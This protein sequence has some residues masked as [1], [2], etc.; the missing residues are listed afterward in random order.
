MSEIGSDL[1]AAAGVTFPKFARETQA[2]LARVLSDLGQMHNP[3]DLTGAAVRDESVW[4]SVPAIVSRD[5][6]VGLTLVNW[7]VPAVAEPTM[8]NTLELVGQTHKGVAT[9]TLMIT[10][11]ERPV[12]EHGLAYLRRHGL[13]FAAPGFGHGIAAVGK[14]AW[15]SERLKRPS[16][17]SA[18]NATG[19][20]VQRPRDERETLAHLA[21]HGVPR[22]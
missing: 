6:A 7:D 4:T 16:P 5:P 18:P 10:N 15:W 12:N 11:L 3:L 22:S 9:P 17:A 19:A 20:A 8:P 1:G 13:P 14:L 21:R 2:E